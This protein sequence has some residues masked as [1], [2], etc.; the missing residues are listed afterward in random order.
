MNTP[1]DY[2]TL[3]P[4]HTPLE[5]AIEK[6]AN[7]K[8][9]RNNPEIIKQLDDPWTCP[10]EFL[11]FL[12]YSLSVDVWRKE[13]PEATKRALCDNAMQMHIQKGTRGGLEDALDVLGV[14]AEITEWWELSPK[15]DPGTIDITLWVRDN[16]MPHADVL[17]SKQYIA[18]LE[19]QIYRN[20]RAT[21]HYTLTLAVEMTTGLR[22]AHSAQSTRLAKAEA[23]VTRAAAKSNDLLTRQAYSAQSTTL[24]KAEAFVTRAAV[25]SNDF[26][27]RQAYSAQSSVFLT[28]EA[29]VSEATL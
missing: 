11:E 6:E 12:A 5:Q 10:V 18:D 1:C 19:Q 15:G 4:H 2:Q 26:L 8:Y 3:L 20:K 7:E 14:R 27:Q 29:N 25:K 16:L 9:C 22:S 28:I 13:W 23:F 17:F 24:A 21:I